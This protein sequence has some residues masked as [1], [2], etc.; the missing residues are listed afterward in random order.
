MVGDTLADRHAAERV[1]AGAFIGISSIYPNT[2]AALEG[3]LHDN[4]FNR[5]SKY[6]S[7]TYGQQTPFPEQNGRGRICPF[8]QPGIQA[9]LLFHIAVHI[10][11]PANHYT[12]IA[13]R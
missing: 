2:P 12:V 13:R 10:Y 11:R 7:R 8:F 3:I 4:G 9:K 1:G 6:Y 5:P